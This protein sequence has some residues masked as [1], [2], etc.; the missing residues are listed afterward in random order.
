M[1]QKKV[2][3]L[4]STYNGSKYVSEQIDSIL[5]QI[6]VDVHLIVRDDGSTD[7]TLSILENYKRQGKLD[8][9]AGNN[10]GWKKSFFN[11]MSKAPECDYYAF[12][13]QDDHWLPEK[14]IK[15]IEKLDSLPQGPRLYLSNCYYWRDGIEKELTFKK[16]PSL[17]KF[18]CHL[19]ILGQ[20]CTYVFNKELLCIVKNNPPN[21]EVEH[22]GWIFRT[23]NLLGSIYYDMN[24]YIWYR[25]HGNNEAGATL[26]VK[27]NIKRRLNYYFHLK[28]THELEIRSKELIGCYGNLMN[29]E[30]YQICEY[31]ANYRKKIKYYLTLLLFPRYRSDNWLRTLGFKFRVLIRQV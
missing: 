2:V 14:L 9:Y 22:D 12:S 19:Y 28:G 25:Q 13:D 6:G 20:G 11:L 26:T 7:D 17:A 15:G 18:N 29:D 5:D 31:V 21:I 1:K 8:Y 27:E 30:C 23:A 10:I 4:L 16:K 24:S 3:V